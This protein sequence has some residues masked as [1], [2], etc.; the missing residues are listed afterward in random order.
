MLPFDPHSPERTTTK[1]AFYSLE[2]EKTFALPLPE[3]HGKV[4]CGLSFG[5]LALMDEAAA[6]T[7]LNP[8]TGNR[9]ALPPADKSIAEASSKSVA[10]TDGDG[11]RRWV[12]QHSS[13]DASP[14]TLDKMRDVFFRGIVFST[15]PNNFGDGCVAMA[16]LADSS[17]VAFCRAG[18]K[19]P[20]TL[21]E[22]NVECCVSSV[23]HCQDRFVAIGCLGEISIISRNIAVDDAQ[24]RPARPVSSLPEPAEMCHRSY[25]QV[26]GQLHLVGVAMQAFHGEWPFGRH[27]VVYKCDLTGETTPVWSMVT[28]ASDFALFVSKDFNMGFGGASVSKIKR[29]CIYLSEPMYS[30]HGEDSDHSPEIVDIATGTSDEISYPITMEGSEALCWI[31][32]NLWT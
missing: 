3:L 15:A 4:V 18:D 30:D 20:W 12:L 27:A 17:E 14:V 19:A 1:A 8:F 13:G 24:P 32:P 16:V 10:V 5:W 2:E 11:G 6:V 22:T 9:V 31:R 7:L 23:V 28:E 29:N 25:L 26:N 21:I